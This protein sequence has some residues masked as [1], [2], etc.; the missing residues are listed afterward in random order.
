MKPIPTPKSIV[1]VA[2]E[3]SGDLHGA[4]LV[5]AMHQKEKH[6]FFCGIGGPALREAGVR[7]L[8]DAAD[9]SVVGIT[10]VLARLPNVL[11]SMGRM[12]KI[13]KSLRPDLLILVDYPDYNMRLAPLAKKLQIPVLYYISPQ[14]WAWRQGR[15]KRIRRM[16]DHMAVILPFEER[17]YQDHDVPVTFVGHPLLDSELPPPAELKS[18]AKAD[19]PMIG[20]VPGSRTNEVAEHLPIMLRAAKTLKGRLPAA[21]FL[22]SKAPS[23]E[24][25]HLNSILEEFGDP[26]IGVI[27]DNVEHLFASC[28]LIVVASGTVTLQAAIYGTPMIIIYKVSPVSYWLGRLLVRVKNIG[29][30]NLVAGKE[31]VPELIQ[32]NASAENIARTAADMLSD[33]DQLRHL[34]HELYA[35]RDLLGQAGASSRVA[36]I[37]L[38]MLTKTG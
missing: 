31:L 13:L 2:G 5:R 14:I 17:F 23:V 26:D 18:P 30:V 12:K 25:R 29:L 6:L 34:R 32:G 15:V 24:R 36:D 28:D 19:C 33:P 8:Y 35:T 38:R 16:V 21:T 27:S 9:L 1:I 22:L 37:A 3:T 10:E 11:Q 7:I 20:L 4:K